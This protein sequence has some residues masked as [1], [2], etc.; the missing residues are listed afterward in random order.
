M[1]KLNVLE[2]TFKSVSH[3]WVAAQKATELNDINCI[4]IMTSKTESIPYIEGFISNSSGFTTL[5]STISKAI[6]ASLMNQ[7]NEYDLYIEYFIKSTI[8]ISEKMKRANLYGSY[9]DKEDPGL[10][11]TE[12]SK[13]LVVYIAK[14]CALSFKSI[15]KTPD[16]ETLLEGILNMN[17]K[18]AYTEKTGKL[19]EIEQKSSINAAICALLIDETELAQKF[20]LRWK[21]HAKYK[22]HVQAFKGICKELIKTENACIGSFPQKVEENF[23][24]IFNAYRHP[25]YAQCYK[26]LNVEPSMNQILLNYLLSCFYLK[27]FKGQ[28]EITWEE[29]R[30][31]MMS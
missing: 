5:D 27:F 6:V 3:E 15:L 1:D 7:T 10:K 9:K 30:P 19:N 12:A 2:A 20:L 24:E 26:A 11:S 17:E 28:T 25:V 29:L 4:K 22:K 14:A 23:F 21:N 18:L 13:K 16:K 31:I 8:S